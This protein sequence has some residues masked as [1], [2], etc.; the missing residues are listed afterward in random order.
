MRQT[1]LVIAIDSKSDSQLSL[2]YGRKTRIGLLI[3]LAL[4]MLMAAGILFL[5]YQL[6]DLRALVQARVETMAGARIQVGSV[7]VNGFRGLRIDDLQAVLDEAPGTPSL[8]ITV[9]NAYID[10]DVVDLLSGRIT[11]DRVQ[12][13]RARINLRRPPEGVCFRANAQGAALPQGV[14]DALAFRVMGKD[15]RLSIENLVGDAGVVFDRLDFDLSRL[16]GA[17]DLRAKIAANLEA[18]PDKPILVDLRFA[19]LGNFDLR[20][21]CEGLSAGDVNRFLPESSHLVQSGTVSPSLRL[22]G[23]PN[24]TLVVSLEVPFEDFALRD[25][26][27]LPIPRQGALTAM[28]NYDIGARLLTLTTARTH[29]DTFAGWIEGAVSFAQ[30]QPFFDLRLQAEEIPAMALLEPLIQ[31]Q[32]GAL[33]EI[34]AEIGEPYDLRVELTG[35]LNQL[36]ISAVAGISSGRLAV[37]PIDPLYPKGELEFGLMKVT[38]ESGNSLP[39]GALSITGGSLSHAQSGLKAKQ[40]TGTLSLRDNV[41]TIEPLSAEITGNPFMGRLRYDLT[42]QKAEFLLSGRLEEVEKTPLGNSIK[43]LQVAGTINAQAKGQI[44]KDRGLMELVLDVTQAQIGFDWWLRKPPGTGGAIEPLTIEFVPRKSITIKGNAT[45]DVT[46]LTGVFDLVYANGTYDLRRIRIDIDPLDVVSAGNCINIPY[47]ASGNKGTGAFFEQLH[48]PDTEKGHRD[49]LGAFFDDISFL[50]DGGDEPLHCKNATVKVL[51]D[52]ADEAAYKGHL[53]VHAEEAYVPPFEKK[54]LLPLK[55]PDLAESFP[56]KPRDWTFSLKADMIQM[57]PW[58][59]FNFEGEVYDR[60]N[61]TG[62]TR[63]AADIDGGGRLEGHYQNLKDDNITTLEARWNEIPAIYL[64]RH[65]NFP[66]LL[67]GAVTGEVLYTVDLDD[68]GTLEGTGYFEVIDGQFS[69]DYLTTQFGPFMGD[70]LGG[71]PASLRFSRFRSDV[72]LKGDIVSTK[73]MHLEAAGI[74]ISGEGHYVVDGDMNY[75]LKVAISPEV[76]GK[77]QVLRDY[78]NIEGHRLTQND[79]ELAFNIH[80]PTFNPSSR[81]TGLPSVAVTLVSGAG[82]MASQAIRL[83]DTPRQIVVD[84]FK[85]IGAIGASGR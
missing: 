33:G 52:S 9:P 62:F 15:C 20:A 56:E 79:I 42:G 26:P 78:L 84:L 18:S 72:A 8:E 1:R 50:P 83:I 16:F 54:W 3:L 51:L 14:S 24:D 76:A 57:T 67:S 74:T 30:A 21:Q 45:V 77:M 38:W 34:K 63:F 70:D 68:P 85:I 58:R 10:I 39:S 13:D 11:I 41:L 75:D 82:E 60:E 43:N 69:A 27:G 64:I 71:F 12:I 53:E 17:P 73:N 25:Y 37:D 49:T 29:S 4:S 47:T 7:L 5:K 65:L 22:A 44:S 23:Y 2:R 40:I 66:E 61:E 48:V 55:A 28:A 36:H 31:E 81:V 19:D 32:T 46:P 80:G 6:E 59:G 35:P